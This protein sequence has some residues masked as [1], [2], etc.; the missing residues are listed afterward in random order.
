MLDPAGALRALAA[1][2]LDRMAGTPLVPGNRVRL[3][4]DAAQNYPAWLEAIAGATRYVHFET[5]IFADDAVGRRFAQAL[6]AKARE[7]VTVRLVYDWMGC[8]G[9]ASAALWRGLREAG[10]DVRVFNRPRIDDPLGWLTRDHRKTISVDGRI[11]F[12]SGLC[13][14]KPWEGDDAHGVRPWRDTGIRIEGPAVADIERAFAQV[15]SMTGAP[16]PPEALAQDDA[17][18]PAGDVSLRVIATMPGAMSMYRIDLLV[19]A[20]AQHRLWLTD[21]YFV[22]VAAHVNALCTASQD[23]VDVRLLVPGASDVPAVAA[24]SRAA[25]RPLLRAGVRVFEWNGPMLHAK[26]AVADD[27]W[28]RIGSSNLNPA[29]WIGNCELDVTVEDA[30]FAQAMADS[31]KRDLEDSTEI[32][33]AGRRVARREPRPAHQ[34]LPGQRTGSASRVLAGTLG[35]GNAVGAALAARRELGPAEA[36][37]AAVVA[38]ALAVA[39]LLAIVFPRLVAIPLGVLLAWCGVALALK[40][41]RLHVRATRFKR[42]RRRRRRRR[43]APRRTR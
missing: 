35:A 41:W 19:A 21:A 42:A 17:C 15:W 16:L 37:L 4:E 26:T 2:P 9:Q 6:A 36:Q 38:A 28:V 7:G 22:G 32:V 3:L 40:A 29:S 34:R 5:Y 31:F 1:R 13:V 27:H 14:A 39:A 12:V 25:Y 24:L 23:G 10:V 11:A 33:L 18:A 20:A 30:G 43:P 8:L